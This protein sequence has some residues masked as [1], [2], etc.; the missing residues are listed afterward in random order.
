MENLFKIENK[1]VRVILEN[2][3]NYLVLFFILG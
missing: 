2:E 1:I 3:G